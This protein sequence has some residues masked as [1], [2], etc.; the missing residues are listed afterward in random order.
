MSL[1]VKKMLKMLEM[2]C[3]SPISPV[4]TDFFFFFK[5]W[6]QSFVFLEQEAFLSIP[7]LN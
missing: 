6:S 4:P 2:H 7:R 3:F 1:N 5:I